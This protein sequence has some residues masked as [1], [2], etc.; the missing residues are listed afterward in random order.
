M[1]KEIAEGTLGGDFD[2]VERA[3]IQSKVSDAEEAAKDEVWGGYRFVVIP[4]SQEPDGLKTI[5]LG[6]GHSSGGETLCGRVITALKSQA[7][8]NESV[9]AGYIERNWPP[10]LKESGAWPLAS[11]RQSFLNGSLTRLLDPDTTLRGKI[12]EFV[13]RG[14]FGLASGRHPDGTYDRVWFNEPLGVDEVTFDPGVFL[15]LKSKASL[16]KTMRKPVTEPETTA[17]PE[18][19]PVGGRGEPTPGPSPEP[20]PTPGSGTRTFRI[21]G[22]LPPEIWNRLGTKVLPKLR[23][24]SDLKIGIEFS[25]TIEGQFAESFEAD[26]KQILEDLGLTGHI[27]IQ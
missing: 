6:A 13:S 9:G 2:R 26:I 10:A 14:D 17:G 3:E 5:D 7:L 11:L 15:L 18:P 25:V 21:F 22:D 19:T 20:E 1:A 16:L 4:D 8:L 24:G 12:V 27:H 23:K